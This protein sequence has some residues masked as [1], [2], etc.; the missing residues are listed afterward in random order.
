MAPALKKGIGERRLALLLVIVLAAL[1]AARYWL[2]LR[3]IPVDW[4][5]GDAEPPGNDLERFRAGAPAIHLACVLALLAT[6]VGLS[7]RRMRR[8]GAGRPGIPTAAAAG[9]V[10]VVAIAGAAL[11]DD[12]GAWLLFA[13]LAGLVMYGA[14]LLA[15]AGCLVAGAVVPTNTGHALTVTGLWAFAVLGVPLNAL[16]VY[17]QGY[18]PI[19]C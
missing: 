9:V 12:V 17:L 5:C 19:I 8:R 11:P 4:G 13:G 1:L 3:P 16:L 14:P 18:G 10:A 6:L 15:A 7:W 2:E